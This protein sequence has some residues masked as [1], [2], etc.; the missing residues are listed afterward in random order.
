MLGDSR[1]NSS[2]NHSNDLLEKLENNNHHDEG[3]FATSCQL[4]NSKNNIHHDQGSFANSCQKCLSK[5][6][7]ENCR[8]NLDLTAGVNQ[9]PPM[10][11][12]R[13]SPF[14]PFCG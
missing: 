8:A 12:L 4:G 14:N 13:M 6:V 10:H 2:K 7:I 1:N 11:Q 3:N 9:Q 5:M